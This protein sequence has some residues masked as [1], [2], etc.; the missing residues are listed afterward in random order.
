MPIKTYIYKNCFRDS[1]Y[2]MRLSSLIRELEGVEGAEVIIGTDHNKK[3]LETGG[4]WTK[5]IEREAESNDLIIAVRAVTEELAEEAISRALAELDREVEHEESV[6]EYIPRTLETALKQL[7]GA[8]LVLLSIPGQHVRREADKALEAGLHVMIFSDNVSLQDEKELKQKAE[9]K[10]L[11][12]MGP[13]CGTAIINGTPLAF[14]NQVRAGKVGIVAAAGTGLQEVSTLIHN[15]GEGITHGIGT[16]GRDLNGEVGGITMRLGL[17]ALIADP[18]TEA[19]V[20]VSKP[21]EPQVAEK[22][23]QVAAGSAKPVIVNFIG[24]S[25]EQVRSFGCEPALTLKEAA[26]KAV[27]A[28][29]KESYR[30]EEMSTQTKQIIEKERSLMSGG[31]KYFRGLFSGGTLAYEAMILLQESL[32]GIYSNVSLDPRF[33]LKDVYNSQEHTIIDFGDDQFTQGRLHPMIDPTT[34]NQRIIAEAKDPQTAI[35]MLDLV[36]GYNAYS[37]PAGAA[38]EAIEEARKA[39]GGRHLVFVVSVCGTDDDPQN[40]QE[41]IEKLTKKNVRVLPSNAD[42]ALFAKAVLNS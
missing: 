35:I 17:K 29:R 9:Q 16:G 21:P 10:G 4:L 40:R 28:L 26:A 39:A 42:A 5:E 25:P 8:N 33:A 22:V 3:F 27:A 24:G 2:L 18:S 1:V 14:A 13:D 15:Y 36:L 7:P 6:G 31:Q 34:R 20:I 19:I 37:D 30:P 11:L 32:G 23:L 12:V 38:P 41:Q